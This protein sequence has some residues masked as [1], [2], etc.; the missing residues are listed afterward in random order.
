M[1]RRSTASV[2]LLGLELIIATATVIL[3]SLAYPDRFRSRLWENGGEE[4]WNSNPKLR[5]YFYAN[6]RE[7]PA[8]PLIWSQRLT[9]SNLAIAILTLV[10]FFARTVMAHLSYLPRYANILYDLLLASLWVASLAGQ[11][12]EDYSDPQH[13]SRYPWYLTHSCSES[14]AVNRS[15]CRLAQTSF[16]FSA[17]SAII[18]IGRLVVE[19][20]SI[21]YWRGREHSSRRVV[22]DVEGPVR[23]QDEEKISTSEETWDRDKG[24][25]SPVLA[26]F[27]SGPDDF[28]V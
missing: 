13:P 5:I 6:H 1:V 17:L 24:G 22:L 11:T 9:D 10:I 15:S 26:F 25:L 21:A 18:Y 4:G 14:W 16:I 2:C 23:Y 19:G 3:F 28:E 7:P 8:I 12:S 27:A 20:L